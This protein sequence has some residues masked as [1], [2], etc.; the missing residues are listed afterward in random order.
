MKI[1]AKKGTP[2]ENTIKGMCDKMTE[3]LQVATDFV[4]KSAGA[5]PNNIFGLYHWGLISFMLPEFAFHPDDRSKINPQVLRRSW[6]CENIYVPSLRYKQ[7][8]EFKQRYKEIVNKYEITDESLHEYGIHQEDYN[9]CSYY[10]KPHH[11]VQRD[12]YYLAC[13]DSIPKAFDK[14]KLAKDQFEIEY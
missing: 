8:K 10:I 4:E 7:G 12:V 9:G 3:G 6:K 11:D 14:K 2:L 1:I 13:S 5:R